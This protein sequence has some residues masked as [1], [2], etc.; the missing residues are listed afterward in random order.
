[1]SFNI[2]KHAVAKQFAEM[3]KGHLFVTDTDKDKIWDTY[4]NAF[5]ENTNPIYRERTEHDCTCCKQ[6]IRAVGNIISIDPVTN[7]LVSIWDIKVPEEPDYQVVA[8]ALSKY[9]KSKDVVNVFLHDMRT[10]GTDKNFE[11]MLDGTVKEWKHFFV[12]I[13]ERFVVNKYVIGT[14]LSENR[15]TFDVFYRGLTELKVDALETVVDLITQNSLYRG[16]EFLSVV[17]GFLA[18]KN[19]F[20]KLK[21]VAA[22]KHYTWMQAADKSNIGITRIRNTAI[23][24]LLIDLSSDIDIEEAVSSF[25]R[26][27]A[28]DSYKRPTAIY[29]EKMKQAAAKTVEELGL[30]SALGRRRAVMSDVTINNVLFADRDVKP[31]MAESPFDAIA[32]S[33]APKKK[34]KNLDKVEEVNIEKFIKDILPTAT[35]LELYLENNHQKNLVNLIA[36][37]DP[38]AGKLFKWDSNFSWAYN[39][40]MADSLIKERVKAAG[41]N[42]D[43]EVCFRLAWSNFDD[44]DLHMVEPGGKHIYFGNYRKGDC[45]PVSPCGGQLDVDMNA[46]GGNTRTPVENIY[47]GSTTKMKSGRYRLYVNQYSSREKVDIGFEIEMQIRGD[48]THYAYSKPMRS[49]DNVDVVEFNY[50]SKT[51]EFKIVNSLEGSTVSKDI[52]G[53]S[54]NQY[55]KVTMAMFSPNHWDDQE[56]GNKH[57]MFM[58]N[59]CSNPEPARGFFNEFLRNDLN[60]HRKVFEALGSKMLCSPAPDELSGLGFSNTQRAS[61]LCKVSGSFNRVIK[62]VF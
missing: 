31:R 57:Y 8:D 37:V 17:S 24:T 52:W 48:I 12:N 1:M 55:H 3:S 19:E 42:V 20:D 58:L 54:T 35:G 16:Q 61:V 41:G 22:K 53:L 46:G 44:L 5:P 50:D 10:A 56:V 30:T 33:T 29:T 14:K 60:E 15:S 26:K 45:M 43:A 34:A 13:P 18:F 27:V 38:T 21:T 51:G 36:P 23:G 4:L 40:N 9:V 49:G 25:E 47:Y 2:I 62:I 7:K 11:E 6:F 59:G 32:D 28:G 39:G